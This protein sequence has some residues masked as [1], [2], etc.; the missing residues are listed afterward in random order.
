MERSRPRVT[1]H[2]FACSAPRGRLA[3]LGRSA[4]EMSPRFRRSMVY[5]AV[6]VVAIIVGLYAIPATSKTRKMPP[7]GIEQNYLNHA[8]AILGW[9]RAEGSPLP[10][11]SAGVFQCLASYSQ[12]EAELQRKFLEKRGRDALV[13]RK[14]GDGFV[15][16]VAFPFERGGRGQYLCATSEKFVHWVEAKDEAA[17]RAVLG[18]Q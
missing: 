8:Q 18:I 2:A 15:M 16:Y 3:H 12:D 17:L 13:Y 7:W 14:I 9:R 1:D 5:A 11:D 4:K 10:A 6:A